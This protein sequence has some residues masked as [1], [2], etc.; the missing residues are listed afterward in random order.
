MKQV[1]L[2]AA[3]KQKDDKMTKLLLLV[4]SAFTW[5]FSTG[6][7]MEKGSSKVCTVF[8]KDLLDKFCLASMFDEKGP[9][10]KIKKSRVSEGLFFSLFTLLQTPPSH[11]LPLFLLEPLSTLE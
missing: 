5:A 4:K 7:Y 11:R 10:V 9:A 1:V 2:A 3:S 8:S 6:I